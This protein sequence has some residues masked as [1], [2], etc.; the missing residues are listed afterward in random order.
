MPIGV[1]ADRTLGTGLD[2]AAA[3]GFIEGAIHPKAEGRR[4][5]ESDDEIAQGPVEHLDEGT[6]DDSAHGIHRDVPKDPAGAYPLRTGG[7]DVVEDDT[8]RPERG[9][10]RPIGVQTCQQEARA[11]CLD[12]TQAR[13]ASAHDDEPTVGLHGDTAERLA[14]V[15]P[16]E[17]PPDD[18]ANA[19]PAG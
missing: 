8:I 10:G 19:K 5:I 1:E 4:R 11:R 3:E 17:Q 2:S 14:R 15:A 7:G 6:H 16:H 12:V 9:I 18:A 13:E